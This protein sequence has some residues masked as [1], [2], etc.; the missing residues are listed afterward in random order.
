MRLRSFSLPIF[1][2]SSK[3][4][5]N[6]VLEGMAFLHLH[7]F[8]QSKKPSGTQ[9]RNLNHG[10]KTVMRKPVCYYVARFMLSAIPWRHWLG[11]R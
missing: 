9:N 10:V 5:V 11:L 1:S 6:S 7:A 4:T 2:F 8:P 3:E